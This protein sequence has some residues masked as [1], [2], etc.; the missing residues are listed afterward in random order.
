M[1]ISYLYS[2]EVSREIITA[3]YKVQTAYLYRSLFV[4]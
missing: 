2:A 1:G 3:L 4:H